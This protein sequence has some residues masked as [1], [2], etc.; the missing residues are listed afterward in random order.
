MPAPEERGSAHRAD[1]DHRPVPRATSVSAV[2]SA[3]SASRKMRRSAGRGARASRTTMLRAARAVQHETSQAAARIHPCSSSVGAPAGR[4]PRGRTSPAAEARR[5][6]RGARVRSADRARCSRRGRQLTSR[7]PA[8]RRRGRNG[9][10]RRGR[11]PVP[12]RGAP[13]RGSP[14]RS[15]A[16]PVRGRAPGRVGIRPCAAHR[17]PA[18]YVLM[19]ASCRGRAT[20]PASR[21]DP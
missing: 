17:T 21:P 9:A 6:G 19:R 4:P 2:S 14:T 10:L 16:R 5:G 11:S 18:T 20:A 7:V 3:Q 12:D 15:V 1:G 13:Q 8:S